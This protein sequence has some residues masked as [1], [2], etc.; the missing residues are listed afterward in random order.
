M[1][2]RPHIILSNDDGIAAVG[3]AHL[4]GALSKFAD[5]LVVAPELDRSSVGH[6]FTLRD[7]IRAKP[8]VS[9]GVSSSGVRH[10][11]EFEGVSVSGYP[12]DAVKFG[13][14]NIVPER[15]LRPVDIVVSGINPGANV[16]INAF[17]SGTVAAAME[18]AFYGIP[19]VAVS[20]TAR[21]G[22]DFAGAA[23][24]AAK[25]ILKLRDDGMLKGG[26]IYNINIPGDFENVRGVRVTRHSLSGFR[27]RYEARSDPRGRKYYWADGEMEILGDADTSDAAA[28]AAGFVS[29]TPLTWDLT[30]SGAAEDIAGYREDY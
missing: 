21:D 12:A 29:V 19:G 11:F 20:I 27:E 3:L 14:K 6:A 1:T 13:I 10:G 8:F 23:G 16:G 4:W 22:L 5:V 17:Y 7:P 26:K 18:G 24:C 30:D 15:G 2:D 9:T 28:V 25:L